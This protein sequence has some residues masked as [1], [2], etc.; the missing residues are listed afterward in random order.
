[1][2]GWAG[3][4]RCWEPWI[5]ATREPEWNWQCGERGYGELAPCAP[6]WPEDLPEETTRVVIGHS[7]G[8]HLVASEVLGRADAI[9]LL[10]SFGTF[11]PPDRTGRRVRAALDGMAAKLTSKS[12]AKEMLRKFL[13]GAAAPQ[14][15]DLL[16]AGPAQGELNLDRLREDLDTLRACD[17][18]PRGFPE[19]ARVLI[20]EAGHDR[21]VDP[22]AQAMLRAALPKADAI[23]FED[24]G[25]ALLQ[26]DVIG[27]VKKWVHLGQ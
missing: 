21:I 18:L 24:A 15:S 2:H 1:M 27:T 19:R 20:V 17:G 4:S 9:V 7:L 10:A 5:G 3:D 14:P 16:P 12:E 8:L 6:V 11:V 13:S 22:V 25:H 26:T 23:R